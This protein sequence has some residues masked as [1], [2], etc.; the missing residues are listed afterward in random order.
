MDA[1]EIREMI[2]KHLDGMK[3]AH[4]VLTVANPEK[5][6]KGDHYNVTALKLTF[7]LHMDVMCA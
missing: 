4:I 2:V 7:W 1:F 6:F 5:N 3:V